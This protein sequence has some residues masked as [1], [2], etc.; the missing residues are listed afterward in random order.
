VKALVIAF[1]LVSLICF[2]LAV[3]DWR[4]RTRGRGVLIL[5]AVTLLT[6]GA[7]WLAATH[8]QWGLDRALWIGF[9]GF[10]ALATLFRPWWF[11]DNYK[12]RWLRALIG[13]EA[14]AF[15]YLAVS[16]V[17][18]WVGLFTDWRFGRQ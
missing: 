16:A 14:T 10:I 2:V 9:G 7:L 4:G 18:V 6:L 3:R 17:M 15:F 13:D 12:A 5:T 11:W 8:E 1:A